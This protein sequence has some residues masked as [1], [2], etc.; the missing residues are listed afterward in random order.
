MFFM[1]SSSCLVLFLWEENAF[2][3]GAELTWNHLMVLREK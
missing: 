3:V 2:S 1:L